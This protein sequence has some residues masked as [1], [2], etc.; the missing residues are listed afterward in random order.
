MKCNQSRPG[1]E[2]VSPCSFPTTITITP[3]APPKYMFTRVCIDK[4]VCLC[5]FTYAYFCAHTYTHT[6]KLPKHEYKWYTRLLDSLKHKTHT[7]IHTLIIKRTLAYIRRT[8]RY[9]RKNKKVVR[10][11]LWHMNPCQQQT[12]CWNQTL[13]TAWSHNTNH[14][15]KVEVSDWPRFH[16][17]SIIPSRTWRLSFRPFNGWVVSISSLLCNIS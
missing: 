10:C 3:R 6:K 5:M 13:M 9:N 15:I 8:K 12:Q 2:L 16:M 7:Y 4:Y 17:L 14:P 1:F 11:F